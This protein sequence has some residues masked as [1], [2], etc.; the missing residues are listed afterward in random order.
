MSTMPIAVEDIKQSILNVAKN[1]LEKT[2]CAAQN[3]RP[4]HE[5][6]KDLFVEA[7]KIGKLCV[8]SLL[9]QAGTG[10]V[11]KQLELSDGKLLNRLEKLRHR[12]Y[13]SVF[14][15]HEIDYIAYGSREGQKIEHVPL[16]VHLSLPTEAYSY[17][18]QD[19][20][21]GSCIE[22]SYEK[23]HTS[24][25]ALL[26]VSIPV[27]GLERTNQVLAASGNAFWEQQ[28]P[29]VMAA[30][31]Q[32][33]VMQN[34]G[35]GVVTRPEKQAAPKI[36]TNFEEMT[37]PPSK[38]THTGRKKVAMVGSVHTMDCHQRTPDDVLESLFRNKDDTDS[39]EGKTKRNWQAPKPLDKRIRTSL[40]RDEKDTLA[41]ARANIFDWQQKEQR[42]RDPENKAIHI[43][44]MDGEKALWDKVAG[45]QLG[46]EQIGILDILHAASYIWV[47]STALHPHARNKESLLNGFVKNKM[48]KVLKGEVQVVI[49]EFRSLAK[50]GKRSDKALQK[51]D[52][53]CGYLENNAG[54]MKYG[55]YLEKGYPIASGVI[56]GA[57][58]YIVKDRMER[59][60]MRWVLSGAEAML[61]L[62][63]IALNG[64]WSEFMAFH[65][66]R[67]QKQRYV[68]AANDDFFWKRESA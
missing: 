17:F 58:R 55:E 56:E 49:R 42:Q 11:G 29:A 25:K 45:D 65:I 4:L 14:G 27:S 1:M 68:A 38:K 57:C 30:P 39:A 18:L 21:E 7:L 33:I 22:T 26:P 3:G 8:D 23:V 31:G 5:F 61:N 6:E 37:S 63:C 60:G 28:S 47:A 54:R 53:A 13:L 40:E 15:S 32:L 36:K 24:F 64:D 34:D 35:K 10:D 2:A 16:A 59:T 43:Y 50:V 51:I 62:R 12:S 41:P 66:D 48:E 9:L 67:V 20:M 19:L 46:R 44:L 52:T